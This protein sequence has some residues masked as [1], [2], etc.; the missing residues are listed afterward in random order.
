MAD[1]ASDSYMQALESSGHA[2]GGPQEDM[3]CQCTME[4][5]TVEDGNYCEYQTAPSLAWHPSGYSAD[6]VKR[7][8]ERQ[9]VD[10]VE[11]VQKADCE[12]DL[13]VAP[14]RPSPLGAART[15][16]PRDPTPPCRRSAGWAR[17]RL[18]GSRISTRCRSQKV[19]APRP[20]TAAW[21]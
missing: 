6:T 20:H 4:D 3:E 8:L 1:G 15:P 10:Y 7:L 18:F 19:A 2:H 16:V 17:V 12:A 9:F 11:A 13:K 14:R 21:L 5:I